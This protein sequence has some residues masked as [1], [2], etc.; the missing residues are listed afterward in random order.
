[1]FRLR[2]H[3]QPTVGRHAERGHGPVGGHAR[4]VH[5]EHVAA[6]RADVDV[7]PQ[8]HVIVLPLDTVKPELAE[9]GQL[10]TVVVLAWGKNNYTT[11]GNTS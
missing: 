11:Q 4:H 1:M 6:V 2:Q 5:G 10:E 9:V 3:A 8:P 7:A